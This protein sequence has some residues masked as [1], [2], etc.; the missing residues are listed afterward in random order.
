MVRIFLAPH[1]LELP[2]ACIEGQDHQHLARVLRIQPGESVLLLD[3]AGNGFRA[4]IDTV[5]KHRTSARIETRVDL[6]GCPEPCPRITV[7][8]ALGKGDKFEKVLQHG[9]E[10]GACGFVP[11][12]SERCVIDL[13]G[14]RVPDKMA[15]WRQILKGAAEQS[16]RSSIPTVIEPM[17]TVDLLNSNDL[18]KDHDRILV[19]HPEAGPDSSLKLQM[20]GWC[21]PQRLLILVGPEG[22]WSQNEVEMARAQGAAAVSLGHRI[23]RTETAALVAIGQI[24]YHWE[25]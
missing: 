10:A 5:G 12:R 23:L 14:S 13:A 20:S 21:P 16:G 25:Q 7:A 2:V 6:S 1:Q 4:T 22:G 15:R 18:L 9:T 11:I 17:K 8:Q 3:G 19:L 24:L